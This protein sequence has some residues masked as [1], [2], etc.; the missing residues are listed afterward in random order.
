[1]ARIICAGYHAARDAGV[2]TG[3]VDIEF[4]LQMSGA[5]I[6]PDDVHPSDCTLDPFDGAGYSDGEVECTAGWVDADDQ[7]LL[8]TADA[9]VSFGTTVGA[10]SDDIDS[11]LV[12]LVVDGDPDNDYV[13]GKY[14][15]AGFGVNASTGSLSLIIPSGGILK[16][17]QAA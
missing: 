11:A 5:T 6:D 15:G 10:G 1:M 2:L 14:D 13:L 3:T 9:S 4:R 16:D 7:W 17:E 8:T 12:V